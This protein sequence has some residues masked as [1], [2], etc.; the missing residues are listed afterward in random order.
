MAAHL[1]EWQALLERSKAPEDRLFYVDYADLPVVRGEGTGSFSG[2]A[3]ATRTGL[4][5]QHSLSLM[6]QHRAARIL[7]LTDGFS[8]EPLSGL[9]ER[10]AAQ[11]V[12]LDYRFATQVASADYGI[13]E[14]RVPSRAQPGEPFILEIQVSGEPD[15]TVPVEVSRDGKVLT[16]GKV[17][18]R[19]GQG[20]MRFTDRVVTPGAHRYSIRL[21]PEKDARSGNNVAESWIEIIGGAR[22]LL[23]TNYTDDP[24]ARALRAQ[25]FEVQIIDH[26]N[27]LNLGHLSGTKGVI[28]N[29]VP[30]YSIPPEF[31]SA[32]DLYVRVQGGGFLMVGG[33]LSF[34]SGGYF[35]SAIDELLPVSMELR[36]EHRKLAVAM[37]VVMDRSGSMAA[38]VAGGVTKMDLAN[39]GVARA[40]EL[41]GP[42]DAVSVLAV[43][44]EPH[45]VVPLTK[46]RENRKDIDDR[47]RRITSGGGGIFVYVGLK[48][49][50]EELKK[51][52]AG[53]R[54]VVLFSDAADSEEPGEYKALIDEM[55]AGG[56][57]ISVIGLGNTLDPD[58]D[59]LQD[60][61]A[62]G[63]GRIFFNAD[64]SSLPGL[65]AQETVA[66]A[67]S[68]F[69]DE[70]VKLTPGVGWMEIAAKPLQWLE[71]VDGYNL[72]YLKPDATGA[73]FSGDEYAAPLIAFWQRGAGRSAVVSFPLGGDFSQR[74]RDW[75]GYGDFTQTLGRWLMG[76][77]LPPGLG[78]RTRVD[79]SELRLD[80]LYDAGW[81]DRLTQNAPQVVVGEGPAGE[82]KTLVWQRIEPGHYTAAMPLEPGRVVRGAV[83]A[84]KFTVPFGPIISGTNPEWMLD[85][86]RRSELQAVSQAS[87]G[88]ERVD[89]AK[90]WKAPRREEFSDLRPWLITALLLVFVADALLTRL[91]WKV[92]KLPKMQGPKLPR[93][94]TKERSVKDASAPRVQPVESG[95]VAPVEPGPDAADAR[96]KRFRQAKR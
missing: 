78:L 54:H 16:S 48:A 1:P 73:A 64:A 20:S 89:L 94:R 80:L 88:V 60:I 22:L 81:E 7:A 46:L 21:L 24:L 57:T 55:L 77:E 11:H 26:P 91:G 69:L 96:R 36:T 50:W 40:I 34:G 85:R 68:A 66:L 61:A 58:A 38:S 52:D 86:E 67:R 32:L 76:D 41:L 83:Q 17:V 63:K 5:V 74:V 42:N 9:A 8:T 33:K 18:V 71:A 92:R 43:D 12:P 45:V 62:R 14:F 49:A 84:G 82:S 93:W 10:L 79:G 6:P 51:S 23:V 13:S 31:L 75:P 56:A 3:E 4:A 27:S 2:S 47:V 53:Q 19:A 70:P 37:A 95:P 29:N 59:L 35:R 65:F 90:I 28:L 15:A 39:E 44:S 72:S 25:G 30:A 87:G